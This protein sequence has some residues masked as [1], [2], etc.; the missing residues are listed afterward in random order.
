M[1]PRHSFPAL[2]T[3][4]ILGAFPARGLAQDAPA[5]GPVMVERA[6]AF[7]ASLSPE[8]AKKAR[9]AFDDPIRKDWHWIPKE[10][11]GLTLGQMNEEQK[12]AA[13]ALL[14]TALS[15]SGMEKARI[16]MGLEAVL[17]VQEKDDSGRRDPEKYH[18]CIFGEPSSHGRWGWSVEGHHISVNVTVDDGKLVAATPLFLGACPRKMNAEI[19]GQPAPDYEALRDEEGSA[20]ALINSL[21]EAQLK[22]AFQGTEIPNNLVAGPPSTLWDKAPIGIAA[23]ELTADQVKTLRALLAAYCARPAPEIGDALLAEIEKADI[24]KVHLAWYGSKAANEPHH[25]RVQGPTFLIDFDNTQ[26]DP[27]DNPANHIH[28]LWRSRTRDFGAGF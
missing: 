12:K 9:F 14:K 6:Q 15:K 13:L 7:L 17:K 4:A 21:D 25:Y 28:S 22:K 1:H 19:E 18:W 23:S 26:A 24:R 3:L 2:L 16:I 10:R 27:L 20:I 8:E 5:A 11:K